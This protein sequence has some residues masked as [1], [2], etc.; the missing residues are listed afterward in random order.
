MNSFRQS[1]NSEG[2]KNYYI[3][4]IKIKSSHLKEFRN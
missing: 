3:K 2:K 4:K 1:P